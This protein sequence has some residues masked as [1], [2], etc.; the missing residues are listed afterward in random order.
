VRCRMNARRAGVDVE[1]VCERALN[2]AWSDAWFVVK[3]CVPTTGVVGAVFCGAGTALG[4][5]G[6]QASF[7]AGVMAMPYIRGCTNSPRPAG[8][9]S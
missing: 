4:S 9:R 3:A 5:G 7:G 1:L 8:L 2:G 6:A